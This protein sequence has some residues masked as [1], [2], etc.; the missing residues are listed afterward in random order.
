MTLTPL[1]VLGFLLGARHAL[2]ADHLVAVSTILSRERTI[3]GAI[4]I[5]AFW[6]IGHSLTILLVGG[7]I[8]ALQWT[9]PPR[10]EILLELPVAVMLVILGVRSMRATT[11]PPG[12]VHGQTEVADPHQHV[13]VHG[14][15]VHAHD[16][17]HGRDEHGH[18]EE[19]TPLG[20]VDRRLAAF[21]AY[22]AARPVIVGVVHGLAGS[23]AVALLIVPL[24]DSM[25]AAVLYLGMFGAGT[26]AGMTAVTASLSVPLTTG[27]QR[28]AGGR[29]FMIRG[30][31]LLSIGFGVFVAGNI[32]VSLG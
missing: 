7:L 25:P 24:V 26:I 10:I 18:R 15:Y 23:A 17:G 12:H 1:I 22:G 6:G 30:V 11:P 16:H 29:T 8:V 13:H 27:V 4:A 19:D 2:D 32:F 31:G 21:R 5:G 3:K 14:D 9:V 20:W 28:W